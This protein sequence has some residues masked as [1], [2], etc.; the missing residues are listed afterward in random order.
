MAPPFISEGTLDD[1]M[2]RVF[3]L[4]RSEGTSIRPGKGEATEVA[5]AFLELCNPRARLSRTEARGKVFS[6]L[7]EFC[8]YLSGRSD[9]AFMEHYVPDYG[10][11][12]TLDGADVVG[13]YGPRLHNW[14][15]VDQLANVITRL[16][17]MDTRRAVIQLF[18]RHDLDSQ[19]GDIPCTN[20]I[21][22]LLRD[23]LLNALVSMRSNDAVLGLPHDVFCFTMLQE[24]I[25]RSIGADVGWYRHVAGS[26]HVYAKNDGAVTRFLDEGWQSTKSPMPPMPNTDPDE[27]V[28]RLIEVERAIREGDGWDQ[29]LVAGLDEYWADLVRLLAVHALSKKGDY[30]SVS[31]V[32]GEFASD[33]Y[34]AFVS[35]KIENQGNH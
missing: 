23:G 30:S 2:R 28:T 14:D 19:D 22:F 11:Y 27:A 33:V 8:W 24:M 34:D 1:L 12:V 5:G 17:S 16:Q 10:A 25:A 29:K 20:T 35:G 6:S 3:E 4:I 21:Q 9:V 7:G 26:L 18:D 32:R 15:G 13:A 31:E